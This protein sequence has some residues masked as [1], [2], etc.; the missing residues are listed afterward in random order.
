MREAIKHLQK[1]LN[2]K[3]GHDAAPQGQK[4]QKAEG[5][6]NLWGRPQHGAHRLPITDATFGS[7]AARHEDSASLAQQLSALSASACHHC[8]AHEPLTT[9][10]IDV[11]RAGPRL[12]GTLLAPHKHDPRVNTTVL[13]LSGSGAPAAAYAG[14]AVAAYLAQDAAVCVFDYRGFGQSEGEPETWG[15]F[16]DAERMYAHLVETLHVPCE[17]LVLHGYAFGATVAAEL[18]ARLTENGNA[19]LGGI[20][21]DRPMASALATVEGD[22][23]TGLGWLGGLLEEDCAEPSDAPHHQDLAHVLPRIDPRIHTLLIRGEKDALGVNGGHV[24][25]ELTALGVDFQEAKLA[26]DA[27]QGGY[28]L[29]AC[30]N[31]CIQAL[32]KHVKNG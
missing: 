4:A 23:S 19:P 25:R 32:C 6:P 14:P 16:V 2:P 1:T 21:Y 26:V 30:C 8:G 12:R 15:L 18:A 24:R 11:R 7:E 3:T 13:Y 5:V 10:D 28:D 22:Q 17:R 29:L 27:S 31:G 20:V 9:I